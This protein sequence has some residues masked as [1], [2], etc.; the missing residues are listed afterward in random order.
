MEN[1]QQPAGEAQ[2]GQKKVWYKK[3]W[4]ILI[5]LAIWPIFAIWYIWKKTTWERPKKYLAILGVIVVA[6][7]FYGDKKS[8]TTPQ[9]Q[10]QETTSQAQQT[11]TQTALQ[12]VAPQ[13]TF[14]VPALVGKSL[15]EVKATLGKPKTFKE[16]TKQDLLMFDTWNIEYEKDG[17]GLLVSYN[18]K[19]KGVVD[20]FMDGHDKATLLAQGNLQEKNDA[21]VV[22]P[23][24]NILDESKITGIKIMKKLP[25]EL[26]ANVTYNAIAFK[27]DN[28]EDYD[29]GNC[30]FEINGKFFG[31]GYVYKAT[32]NVK[33][34]DSLVIPFS[35]F[36]QDGKRFNFFS[37]KPEKLF[38][39][40]DVMGQHRTNFFGIN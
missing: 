40:C 36:T 9:P 39:S 10:A 7:L 6:A 31:G 14:D 11:V 2:N 34:N 22:E 8:E 18:L 5:A 4:G 33:A 29:W 24:K 3:W 20:F 38:I 23:V 30:K 21:Y 27:I 32:K 26:D 25:Q 15:D 13:F 19:T 37:E 35:E 12:N 1:N 17:V 28:K 16:P